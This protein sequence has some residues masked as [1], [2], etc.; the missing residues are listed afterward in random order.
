MDKIQTRASNISKHPGAIDIGVKRKRRTKE[1]I[2]AESAKQL[3]AKEGLEQKKNA[4]IAR[5]AALENQLA[6][7]D[8]D[9]TEREGRRP[10]HSTYHSSH[11]DLFVDEDPL[12]SGS[13]FQPVVA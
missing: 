6:K 8:A 7:E 11:S 3:L 5:I 9:S 12:D 4:T 1:E 13:D 10:Q 2:R